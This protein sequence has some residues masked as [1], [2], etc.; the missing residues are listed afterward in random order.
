MSSAP[1][2]D[3]FD[4]P[5]QHLEGGDHKGFLND[6]R[7]DVKFLVCALV[8]A[9]GTKEYARERAKA[10]S[11]GNGWISMGFN[12]GSEGG[13]VVFLKIEFVARWSCG[14]VFV[15]YPDGHWEAN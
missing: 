5:I 10:H 3:N 6:T 13:L 11:I 4:D 12:K 8:I 14:G 15:K 1:I 9:S 7:A 2:F